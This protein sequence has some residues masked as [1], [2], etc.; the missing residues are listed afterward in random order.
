[1]NVGRAHKWVRVS[2]KMYIG[3]KGVGIKSVPAYR[4][5]SYIY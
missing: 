1:M 5:Y 4:E 2:M 3:H